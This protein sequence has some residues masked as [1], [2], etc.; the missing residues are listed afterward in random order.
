MEQM[1]QGVICV[2]HMQRWLTQC[3]DDILISIELAAQLI[4][5]ILSVASHAVMQGTSL[6]FHLLTLM[7]ILLRQIDQ[8]TIRKRKLLLLLNL[9]DLSQSLHRCDL[10]IIGK[11]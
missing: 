9:L 10:E 1:L 11:C 8:L 5:D 7:S 3:I 4:S 6:A 2:L